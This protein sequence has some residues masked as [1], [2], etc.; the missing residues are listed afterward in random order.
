MI[1]MET[2]WLVQV[3]IV[4]TMS[5]VTAFVGFALKRLFV[6]RMD[7]LGGD[8]KDMREEFKDLSST[9][10]QMAID[11]ERDMASVKQ[12]ITRIETKLDIE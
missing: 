9:V 1:T 12:R 11:R 7:A 10:H 6:E 5:V 3:V 2:T 4:G 8:I